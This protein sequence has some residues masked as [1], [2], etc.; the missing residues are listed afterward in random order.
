[1]FIEAGTSGDIAFGS[2][3]SPW[4]GNWADVLQ[5]ETPQLGSKAYFWIRKSVFGSKKRKEE[6]DYFTVVSLL[7][8]Y[9]GTC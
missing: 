5:N 4:Q 9:V 2:A 6:T 1:M 8:G 7:T 3:K